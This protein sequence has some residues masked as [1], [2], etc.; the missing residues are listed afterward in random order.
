MAEGR[1][2]GEVEDSDEE[3][4]TRSFAYRRDPQTIRQNITSAG[5]ISPIRISRDDDHKMIH[6]YTSPDR[7]DIDRGVEDLHMLNRSVLRV[8]W[9]EPTP[10]EITGGTSASIYV[11]LPII[12]PT[13][14]VFLSLDYLSSQHHLQYTTQRTSLSLGDLENKKL[15]AFEESSSVMNETKLDKELVAVFAHHPIHATLVE[16]WLL[17]WKLLALAARLN[18][19]CAFS[20][21]PLDV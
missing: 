17:C 8:R 18:D 21:R 13:Y 2:E 19:V 5:I 10:I 15:A 3:N 20:V 14:T 7:M 11:S 4:A 1:V 16:K 9:R 12:I 6:G